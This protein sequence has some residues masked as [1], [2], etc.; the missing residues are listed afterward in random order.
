MKKTLSLF[1]AVLLLFFS[2][3][4]V[5]FG[6]KQAY[7]G[8]TA[9][10]TPVVK[11][12][13]LF[14]KKFGSNYKAAP[15]P[16]VAVDDTILFVSGVKLYKLNAKTGEEIASVKMQGS[17]LYATV[18]PLYADGKVF[19]ALDDGIVQAF[20][21]AAMQSLWVYTDAVGGQAISPLAYDNGYVYTGFWVS[22]T[23]SA[24]YVCLRSEDENPANETENKTATW[25]YQSPGG[26]Y[27]AG[28][29]ITDNYVI[30]GTDDGQKNSENNSKIIALNRYS[31][32]EVS[33]LQ[34]KGDIRSSVTYAAETNSYYVS[35]KAG[36]IY[37]FTMDASGNLGSLTTY[38]AAGA[39]TATPV[40]Y[41]G[42]LYAGC[43]SGTAGKFIVLD[44]RTMKEIYT[45]DM[46]GYPQASMLVSTAYEQAGGKIYIYATYNA[47][48]GGITVFEDSPGQTAAVKTE[49]FTPASEMQ[50]YCIS[51][52][53]AGANGT[54][55]YKNDSGYIFAVTEDSAVIRS[56]FQRIFEAIIAFFAKI[57]AAIT[58]ETGTR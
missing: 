40:V 36:Y 2:F 20:D 44:A 15:T 18:A 43:Q 21:Y 14:S 1:L 30:V 11:S 57:T 51:T 28:C 22:E 35:S 12:S 16:I 7:T 3:S 54:L 56:A 55:Y 32:K 33:S 58:T 37:K 25:T 26:F 34:V 39:V 42:R 23:E 31:G 46:Q 41:G 10:Y 45:C 24:N 13:L 27:W 53:A 17:T 29:C 19:V 4:T 8:I 38:T 5:A 50:Q 49:F 48:P 47:K 9:V 6:T 52:I